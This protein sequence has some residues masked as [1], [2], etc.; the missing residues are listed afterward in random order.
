MILI[1]L[2]PHV[3]GVPH[4]DLAV[5]LAR[6]VDPRSFIGSTPMHERLPAITMGFDGSKMAVAKQVFQCLRS[7]IAELATEAEIAPS[8]LTDASHFSVPDRLPRAHAK[9]LASV[10]SQ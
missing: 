3:D 9:E 1:N 4:E 10:H 2:L 8:S 7:G 5:Y 6:V